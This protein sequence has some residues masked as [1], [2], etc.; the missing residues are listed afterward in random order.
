MAE[1]VTAEK[2][3]GLRVERDKLARAKRQVAVIKAF[4]IHLFVFVLVMAILLGVNVATR[5]IWW[6]QWPLLG[7]G[8]VILGHAFAVYGHLPRAIRQWEIRKI[9]ELKDKM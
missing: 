7:W 2:D 9:R 5:S 1:D 3:R 4:Y 8:T 6:V